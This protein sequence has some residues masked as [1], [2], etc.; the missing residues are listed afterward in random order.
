MSDD[1]AI[2]PEPKSFVR[3]NLVW[4]LGIV[5]FIM[6]AYQILKVS[7]GDPTVT[8]YLINNLDIPKFALALVLPY[9]PV[10][11]FWIGVAWLQVH[12]RLPEPQKSQLEW[13]WRVPVTESTPI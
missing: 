3:D 10:A 12:S 8:A 6:A 2:L 1:E 13:T 4:I 5:P 7:S 9:V 11:G